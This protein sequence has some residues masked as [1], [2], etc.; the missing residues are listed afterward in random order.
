PLRWSLGDCTH[1]VR[2]DIEVE[3][4]AGVLGI[5]E[6]SG[7]GAASAVEAH[8]APLLRAQDPMQT[9]RV[10]QALGA[11]LHLPYT[12]P[13]SVFAG[14]E[15]ACLDA[16][17][18]ALG[19]PVHALLGGAVRD[20]V[21]ICAIVYYREAGGGGPHEVGDEAALCDRVA[22]LAAEDHVGVL[23]LHGGVRP[24][25]DE[26]RLLERLQ[27]QTPGSRWR[28]DPNGAW[29]VSTA[30]DVVRRLLSSNVDLEYLEDPVAHLEGMAQVRR[31][32]PVPLATNMCVTGFDDLAPAVRLGSV[33]VVLADVHYWGGLR[34]NQ[35]MIAVCDAF[36]LGVGLHGH[37]ELGVSL[38]AMVHLA[39][40]APSLTYAIDVQRYD[41]AGD[42]VQAPLPVVNGRLAVPTSPGLGVEL[43]RDAVE[44]YHRRY[45]EQ[46]T[47]DTIEDPR[48]GAW[49]VTIPV[50]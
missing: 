2:T 45:L 24:P 34:A 19:V 40:A 18:K 5:G 49:G 7:P 43:D 35:R 12:L 30:R 15:M 6:T 10:L 50:Y 33:D 48:L 1:A 25:R 16:V 28:L 27:E 46:D 47:G 9:G 4:D 44:H 32:S 38:A 14:V 26:V 29:S 3:T 17:G 11:G 13:Q 36:Q 39:A 31:D 37:G 21:D 8:V 20:A 23:K 41:L 22:R 42:I